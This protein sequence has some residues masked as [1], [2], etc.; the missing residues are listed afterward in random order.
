MGGGDSAS[1]PF[2]RSATERKERNR[3]RRRGGGSRKIPC[4]FGQ[5]PSKTTQN[6]EPAAQIISGSESRSVGTQSKHGIGGGGRRRFRAV[7]SATEQK[8]GSGGGN[9]KIPLCGLVRYR[10]TDR[11]KQEIDGGNGRPQI[12][13][14]YVGRR[15]SKNT[16]S[17]RSGDGRNSARFD[18]VRSASYRQKRRRSRLRRRPRFRA[19]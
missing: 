16:R 8:Y 2:G 10:S 7:R 19:V 6:T 5:G 12:S 17:R 11:P 3:R 4:C 18:S 15:P 13:R 9:G 14:R 1:V